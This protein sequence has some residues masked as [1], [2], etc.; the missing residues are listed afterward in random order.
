MPPLQ[1]RC[2]YLSKSVD[3]VCV[4]CRA[5]MMRFYA[6]KWCM[7]QVHE[8]MRQKTF[9]QNVQSGESEGYSERHKD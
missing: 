7:E 6:P 9:G 5:R 1:D 2:L 8:S 4:S 3:T